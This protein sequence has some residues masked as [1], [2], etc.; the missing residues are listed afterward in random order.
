MSTVIGYRNVIRE[1]NLYLHGAH[2][3][4]RRANK[5]QWDER[6][7]LTQDAVYVHN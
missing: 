3:A 1:N 5:C 4:E 6:C 2:N 7:R